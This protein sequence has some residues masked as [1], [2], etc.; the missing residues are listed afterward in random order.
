MGMTRAFELGEVVTG[1][2]GR[3]PPKIPILLYLYSSFD[4]LQLESV[5]YVISSEQKGFC[6]IHFHSRTVC[7]DRYVRL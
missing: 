5:S 1:K 7:L 4:H 3:L 2:P 6:C